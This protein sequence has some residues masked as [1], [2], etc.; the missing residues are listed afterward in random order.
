LRCLFLAAT[1]T[2]LYSSKIAAKWENHAMTIKIAW[3]EKKSPIVENR[4]VLTSGDVEWVANG[5]C[6]HLRS[7]AWWN[8]QSPHLL[9]LFI[10]RHHQQQQQ[11]QKKI[12][13]W[14]EIINK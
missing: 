1:A 6:P 8:A 13:C 12:I 10:R 11:Q 9:H 3:G 2:L 14:N 4:G 7:H 5:S